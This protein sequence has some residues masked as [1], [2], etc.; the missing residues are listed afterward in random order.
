[1]PS[2]SPAGWLLAAFCTCSYCLTSC[3]PRVPVPGQVATRAVRLAVDA[4]FY[5][6]N[7][8]RL[9]GAVL[10][11]NQ[12]SCRVLEKAGFTREALHRNKGFKDGQVCDI[13]LFAILR[14]Q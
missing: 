6:S 2:K 1:M 9:E 5:Y 12:A 4:V 14:G 13:V 11:W 7:M 10:G 8:V 3:L